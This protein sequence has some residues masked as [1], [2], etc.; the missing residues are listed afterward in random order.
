MGQIQ[1]KSISSVQ[2]QKRWPLKTQPQFST[3]YIK[4]QNIQFSGQPSRWTWKKRSL[5]F[6]SVLASLG[7]FPV[8]LEKINPDFGFLLGAQTKTEA[9]TYQ[10]APATLQRL[11]TQVTELANIPRETAHPQQL[12]EAARYI[13]RQWEA[14][15]LKVTEQPFVLDGKTYRNL[16]VSFEPKNP[17]AIQERV[18]IGAH[19]DTVEGSPGADDNASGV[20]GLLELARQL[21]NNA[22][23]LN[24]PVDLVA[25]TLEE[26]H[27]DAQGNALGAR[28]SK[29]HVDYLK[30]HHIPV[31]G[32][33]SLEMIG[34]FSTKKGTQ[35]YPLPILERL[36]PDSANFIA[37]VGYQQGKP[38]V[39]KVTQA[40]AKS[41]TIDAHPMYLPLKLE[42]LPLHRS[43]H[44]S[45]IDAGIPALML[46]DTAEFR[47]HTYHT[48]ADTPEKLNYTE[49]AKVIQGVYYFLQTL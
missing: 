26:I 29:A 23:S 14:L 19:Y 4:A 12:D 16:W 41:R 31:Q 27:R 2:G 33:I 46:T 30:N 25:Y 42:S 45:F 48:E 32:M 13:K 37:V 24:A 39:E 44:S 49:M 6:L 18:I 8:I 11:K 38:W 21:K 40:F 15:G 34:S 22:A 17:S 7:L 9:H 43:D 1:W 20:V 3:H 35:E 47:N 36:Y 5:V 10:P 28:G